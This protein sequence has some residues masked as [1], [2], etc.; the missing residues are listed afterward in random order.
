MCCGA[1]EVAVKAIEAAD[2]PTEAGKSQIS[3]ELVEHAGTVPNTD[4]AL[5][6]G[7]REHTLGWAVGVVRVRNCACH[8]SCEP[9]V[10]RVRVAGSILGNVTSLSIVVDFCEGKSFLWKFPE[11]SW[12]GSG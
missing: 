8:S 5:E 9:G 2:S 1:A 11:L 7:M 3:R 10:A 4:N 12:S 6:A